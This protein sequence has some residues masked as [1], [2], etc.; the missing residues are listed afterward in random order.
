MALYHQFDVLTNTKGDS[1]VGFQVLVRDPASGALIPIYGDENGTPIISTSGI[2]D[3]ALTDGAGNYSLFVEPGTYNLEYRDPAGIT[4]GTTRQVPMQNGPAG[5][6]GPSN[7]TRETLADLKAADT[8]DLTSLYSGSLWTWTLGNFTGQ[9]DDINVVKAGSTALSIGAWVRQRGDGVNFDGRSVSAKLLE[10]VSVKD[11]RFVGGAKG[12]G[13]A[14]DTAAIL[15]ADA[16]AASAGKGLFLPAGTFMVDAE[17]RA[18]TSWYGEAGTI[19]KYRGQATSFV[20]LVYA[21][22]VDGI[23]FEGLTF[24]GGV[25]A[26]PGAWTASNYDS[27]TGASGLSVENCDRPRIIRCHFA[28]TRQHGLRVVS[29]TGPSISLCTTKRSRG[30]FGDGFYLVSNVGLSVSLCWADDYTRIGFVGDSNGDSLLTSHKVSFSSLRATNG[31]DASIMYGGGEFNAGIWCEHTGDVEMTGC[32]TGNNTHRGINVCTGSK[33]N[34]FFGNRAMITLANCHTD[35]GSWGIYTYS[36]GALP[37]VVTATACTSKGA[38][39]GFEGDANHGDDSFTWIGCQADYD[40]ANGTGRGFATEAVGTLASKPLFQVIDCTIARP[41]NTTTQ[42][43]LNDSGDTAATADVGSYG[44]P[45]A[46][47]TSPLRLVVRNLKHVQDKPVYVRWYGSIAHKI[48]IRDCDFHVRRGGG[49]AGLLDVQGGTIR[50]LLVA[51]NGYTGDVLLRPAQVRGRITALG[52]NIALDCDDI[53]M[54]DESDVFLRS[55]AGNRANAIRVRADFFKAINANGPVLRLGASTDA[56]TATVDGQFY[57]DGPNSLALPFIYRG[58][59]MNVIFGSVLADATV[60]NMITIDDNSS[61][62]LTP[63]GVRKVALH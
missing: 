27:F 6:P 44:A 32:F 19:I 7:N 54:P 61:P 58:P 20:R 47:P 63:T 60:T 26:D 41:D 40:A 3:I 14:N 29:C 1:L 15:A 62:E 53:N 55:N 23:T 16:A 9:A 30:A 51:G 2:D 18:T 38:R 10:T 35:G 49:T 34:G 24:D 22:G 33:S 59:N 28:N 57:N 46:M 25:S 12:N 42:A 8:T 37:V 39:I 21:T 31:H 56:C 52:T 36:L 13:T 48:E 45:G 43:N 50:S 4:T 11:A 17:L 5:T